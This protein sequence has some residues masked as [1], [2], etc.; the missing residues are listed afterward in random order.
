MLDSC[1]PSSCWF[2]LLGSFLH[3][4]HVL[5]NGFIVFGFL[6]WFLQELT[7]VRCGHFLVFR[8]VPQGNISTP[9]WT[10][11]FFLHWRSFLLLP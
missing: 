6:V 7:G 4:L 3:G 9:G 11:V 1:M 5:L 8:A 2:P 10:C